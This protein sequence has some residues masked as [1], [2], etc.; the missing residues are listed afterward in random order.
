MVGGGRIPGDPA[1]A[2]ENSHEILE[3]EN[4]KPGSYHCEKEE[5]REKKVPVTRVKK[6]ELAN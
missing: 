1:Q 6:Q 4:C 5:G 2:G 3:G